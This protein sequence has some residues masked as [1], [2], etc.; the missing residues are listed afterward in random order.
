MSDLR[1][2]SFRWFDSPCDGDYPVVVSCF[3]TL[4]EPPEPDFPHETLVFRGRSDPETLSQLD[5]LSDMARQGSS[6][7]T[8]MLYHLLHHIGRTKHQISLAVPPAHLTAFA[9]WAT[10]A[11]AIYIRRTLSFYDPD[12]LVLMDS[13][14]RSHPHAVLPYPPD[15]H[16][17]KQRTLERLSAASIKTLARMPPTLGVD[18][19]TLR[20]AR[21]VAG[22]AMALML[23]AAQAEAHRIGRRSAIPEVRRRFSKGLA[24]LS[25]R[26]MAFLA[27]RSPDQEILDEMD[28][29]YEALYLLL[30]ALG[31]YPVLPEPPRLIADAA[32]LA[33]TMEAMNADPHALEAASLRPPGEI[34][35]ALDYYYR[36]HW[37][38]RQANLDGRPLANIL[39][40]AVSER[41]LA[42]NWLTGFQNLD[43]P[44]D[45]TDNPT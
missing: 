35:D 40:V 15:A 16:E 25:G 44:W 1:T 38:V 6:E 18:E 12:G 39:H 24:F 30:W 28:Q 43:K 36:L 5:V 19:V 10:R 32:I 22:R 9:D 21:N 45:E 13:A 33:A 7:M 23:V 42:L 2:A 26:E 8:S 20:P 3:S 11:N 34:L 37:A 4:R 27:D 29:R 14:G 17:R 41:H 31:I